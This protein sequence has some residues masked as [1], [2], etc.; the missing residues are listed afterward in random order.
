ML[1]V[2]AHVRALVQVEDEGVVFLV[3]SG[4]RPDQAA[5]AG[6]VGTEGDGV[7]AANAP[8]PAP[9]L[10]DLQP[11]WAALWADPGSTPGFH[12]SPLELE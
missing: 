5:E 12:I 6:D 7:P 9:R 11:P 10:E 4:V 8:A 1:I 3:R 2:P